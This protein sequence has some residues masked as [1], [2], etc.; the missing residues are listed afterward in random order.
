MNGN[1]LQTEVRDPRQL[2]PHPEYER[3]F[4]PA[5][6]EEMAALRQRLDQGGRFQPLLVTAQGHVLA[7]VE[8]WQ[9]ALDLGWAS[10]SVMVAPALR[11][12][13]LRSVMV[14]ENIRSRDIREEHLWRG[15]NNF[16]DM[17]PLRPPGGW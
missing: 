5:S 14:A 7:G 1:H 4:E 6:P 15:M 2:S 11:P 16:F 17:E 12:A 8:E 10:I 9:A 13:E 3:L